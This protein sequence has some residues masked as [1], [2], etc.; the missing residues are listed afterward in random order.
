MYLRSN[1]MVLVNDFSKRTIWFLK[2]NCLIVT[3]RVGDKHKKFANISEFIFVCSL[4]IMS[5]MYT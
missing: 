2:V 5:V 3:A 1:A 4:I